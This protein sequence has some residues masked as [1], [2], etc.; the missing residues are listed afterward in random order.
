MG[1]IERAIFTFGLTRDKGI[2]QVGSEVEK[3][4][5]LGSQGMEGRL[6]T[7]RRD[8]SLLLKSCAEERMKMNVGSEFERSNHIYPLVVVWKWKHRNGHSWVSNGQMQC[9]HT[10][11]FV[12]YVNYFYKTLPG[13]WQHKKEYIIHLSND[14]FWWYWESNLG[15]H[16]S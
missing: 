14:L 3:Q 13:F 4:E 1:F 16:L 9:N 7:M 15:L 2:S 12:K 11:R 10:N 6:W 8:K 5:F